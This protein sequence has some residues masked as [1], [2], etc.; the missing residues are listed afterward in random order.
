MKYKSYIIFIIICALFYLWETDYNNRMEKAEKQRYSVT[1]SYLP[2]FN[3]KEDYKNYFGLVD[4]LAPKNVGKSLSETFK[5]SMKIRQ[6]GVL[7]LQQLNN[8]L[9]ILDYANLN[10]VFI[11][12]S[13]TIPED[14]KH[15]LLFY[16]EAIK[17]GYKNIG[18]TIATNHINANEIV[19]NIITQNGHVR[20]VKGYY[21]S[22]E[23]TDWNKV[24]EIFKE[25]AVK[26][27][28]SNNFHVIA[29]HDFEILSELYENFGSSPGWKKTEFGFFYSSLNYIKSQ[30]ETYKIS[31]PNKSLYIPYGR[32]YYYL[33]DNIMLLDWTNIIKRK[34]NS[35]GYL[36]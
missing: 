12:I 33:L 9:D 11:W 34:F 6:L 35:I 10:N 13:A 18:I 31:F 14:A 24:T 5:I 25:N 3:S 32:I 29:T 20:L 2:N 15:E 1:L 8:F 7:P 19:D 30:N 27:L 28:K 23:V 36:F 16:N 21:Y 26:L 22:D 17:K 4:V